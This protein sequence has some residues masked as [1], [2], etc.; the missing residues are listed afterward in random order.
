M[1]RDRADREQLERHRP[2]DEQRCDD[3]QDMQ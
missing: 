2:A 1:H 3:E